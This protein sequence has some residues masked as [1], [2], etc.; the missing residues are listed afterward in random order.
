MGVLVI[1]LRTPCSARENFRCTWDHLGV[2][3]TS[4]GAPMTSLG[5]PGRARD[6]PGSV[7]DKSVNGDEK[8]GSTWERLR[9]AWK[10]LESLQS[11][12]R[13]TTSLGT[14]QVRLEIIAT[15]YH[16]STIF[17][18]H[19]FSLYSQLCIYIATHSH[20]IAGLV[21]HGA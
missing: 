17:E 19:V 12:L 18:T 3:A 13:R 14:V 11:C 20:R 4:L 9:Q 16:C 5:V 10:H 8:P 21:A 2:P 1:G 15:T 6:K 7:N